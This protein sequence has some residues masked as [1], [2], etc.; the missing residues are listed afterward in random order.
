VTPITKKALSDVTAITKR[1]FSDVP[2]DIGATGGRISLYDLCRVSIMTFASVNGTIQAEAFVTEFAV[3]ALGDAIL[4]TL[5]ATS[6]GQGRLR[7]ELR[8]VVA[9]AGR[10]VRQAGISTPA[11]ISGSAER[12]GGDVANVPAIGVA[13]ADRDNPQRRRIDGHA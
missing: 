12:H 6:H 1:R 2:T 4:P 13:S 8:A 7:H 10:T 3:E 5:C 11:C 9:V